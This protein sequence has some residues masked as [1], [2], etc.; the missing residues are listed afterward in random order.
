MRFGN[1][2]LIGVIF[3]VV[4]R[5]ILYFSKTDKVSELNSGRQL[6]LVAM[7]ILAINLVGGIIVGDWAGSICFDLTPTDD[8]LPQWILIVVKIILTILGAVLTYL[9]GYLILGLYYFDKKAFQ[10]Y[11]V[12]V[13]IASILLWTSETVKYDNNIITNTETV[14]VAESERELIQFEGIIIQKEINQ[15]GADSKNTD[16]ENTNKD[17]TGDDKVS[18]W[19]INKKGEGQYNSVSAKSCKIKLISDNESPYVKT[20][21][22]C[23]QTTTTNNNNGKESTEKEKEWKEYYFY[24]P[25]SIFK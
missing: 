8:E 2:F 19:Y 24:V 15:N 12:I 23:K 22:K 9:V 6:A 25:E 21:K 7:A 11:F 5:V 10:V 4:T 18:Y 14:V 20:V 13:F 1:F 3:V 16:I 17:L